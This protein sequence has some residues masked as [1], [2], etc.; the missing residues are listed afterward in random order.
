[1]KRITIAVVILCFVLVSL[2][3]CSNWNWLANSR[4]DTNENDTNNNTEQQEEDK[5]EVLD[6]A[7]II[8]Q[9][10][11]KAVSIDM[12]AEDPSNSEIQF[13]YDENNRVIQCSY[14]IDDNEI[15]V[16]YSYTGNEVQIYAFSGDVLAA[17][18]MFTI[19]GYDSAYGFTVH[20]GYYFRG[21]KF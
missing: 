18:E 2:T 12:S 16:V 13:V 8:F 20:Q 6:S 19:A 10:P 21:C 9:V 11:N 3:G 1:M 17:D 15:R 5:Q 4:P 14:N 7:G